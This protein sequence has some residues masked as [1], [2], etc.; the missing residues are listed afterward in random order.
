MNIN[1]GFDGFKL[2]IKYQTSQKRIGILGAS[3][4]GK[5][6]T[7]KMIAGV[8]NP[9]NGYIAYN[10]RVFYD[11]RGRQKKIC[12]RPQDRKVGYLF[13][14]YALF[15]TM[16]VVQNIEA[17]IVDNKDGKAATVN[18]LIEEFRLEGLQKLYPNQLSGGQ[19]QRVAL[20]RMLAAKPQMILLDE[21]LSALDS[22]LKDELKVELQRIF[23]EFEGTVIWVSHERDEIR[24]FCEETVLID[25]GGVIQYGK[26]S[27]VFEKPINDIASRLVGKKGEK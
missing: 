2:N 14:N 26:T 23:D 22:F 12:M 19:Q 6:L 18:R 16:T 15:P 25:K 1:K 5:S 10:D 7:L 11:N 13:Q 8:E 3:G 27:E 17:G 24:E 4:S 21:P 9:S 20:A